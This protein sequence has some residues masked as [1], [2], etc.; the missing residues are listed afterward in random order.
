MRFLADIA[1]FTWESFGEPGYTDVLVDFCFRDG[2]KLP[3]FFSEEIFFGVEVF[4]SSGESVQV[5][6]PFQEGERIVYTDQDYIY[7]EY[8]Y[9]LIPDTEYVFSFWAVYGDR[10]FSKDFSIKTLQIPQPY[11]QWVYNTEEKVWEPPF[12]P[13]DDEY[14]YTWEPS[15]GVWVRKLGYNE[16]TQSMMYTIYNSTLDDWVPYEFPKVDE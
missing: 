1:T 14:S 13:P 5:L 3:V 2:E 10:K 6:T 15:L 9:D 4:D 12:S 8:V 16:E 7:S 11:P